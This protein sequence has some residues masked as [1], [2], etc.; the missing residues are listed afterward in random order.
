MFSLG[1]WDAALIVAVAVQGTVLAYLPEPRWKAFLL[2]LPIPF[3]L[4]T[5]ALGKPVNATHVAAT[6]DLYCFAQTIRW[7]H[8]S[9]QFPI[10]P[11]IL[12]GI[13]VYCGLG[14]MLAHVLPTTGTAFWLT[15]AI[16]YPVAIVLYILTPYKREPEHKTPLPVRLKLPI[17][18]GVVFGLVLIKGALQGFMTVFPMVGVPAAYESRHSLWTMTR[19]MPV[20][21]LTIVP[22]QIVCRLGQERLGLG[23]SLLLAWVVFLALIIP[24]TRA[25]WSRD[26][27][28]V[29]G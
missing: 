6:L 13:C 16:V 10:V 3:T 25:Q 20:I 21:I 15:C 17:M 9:R 7:L 11:S 1:A 22:M 2:S 5:L 29:K 8:Q 12:T 26:Q 23:H 28:T 19:Q 4:A 14:M 24:L 18:V 27:R